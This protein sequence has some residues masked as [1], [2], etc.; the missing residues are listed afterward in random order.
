[1]TE[2]DSRGL[3]TIVTAN[4]VAA[5]V[6]AYRLLIDNAVDLIVLA[7]A[8]RNRTFV[9]PSSREILG[10]EPAELL[11]GDAYALV[12]PDDAH[13]V[14]SRFGFVGPDCPCIS[15]TFRMRRKDGTFI[16]VEGRYRYLPEDGGFLAMLRDITTQK[17]AE[18]RLI[19]AY[20]ELE[21]ANCILTSLASK[22]GLTGLINR[23]RFDELLQEE[24]SRSAR[25]ELPLGLVLLDVD[26]FKRYNDRYGHIAGDQCLIQIGQAIQGVLRRP[27]DC[28]ARYGGEEIVVLLPAT[29]ADGA[30]TMAE[31]M[32]RAVADLGLAHLGNPLGIA[33]VS[34]GAGA[35]QPFANIGR[36]TDLVH[37]TDQALYRAK[38]DGRNTVR[39]AGP[40]VASNHQRGVL[41]DAR[42]RI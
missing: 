41:V 37:E 25:Q 40:Q 17:T 24:F 14:R 36:P 15:M 11:G 20:A 26:Y 19:E 35:V 2:A 34:A 27:G 3:P 18:A 38:A 32:R 30:M 23:R 7:D 39:R 22:D 13:E 29:D 8:H 9:S 12:H 10:F 31:R 42:C 4:T 16:W 6:T 21:A 28:A 33:T 5:D 1:M